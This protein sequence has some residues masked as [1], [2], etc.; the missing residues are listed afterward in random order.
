MRP[1][2]VDKQLKT[3]RT[4]AVVNDSKK[5]RQ[6][7]VLRQMKVTPTVLSGPGFSQAALTEILRDGAQQVPKAAIESEVADYIEERKLPTGR[8]SK[9]TPHTIAATSRVVTI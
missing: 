6:G 8:I 3:R 9:I 1:R 7:Q 2:V 4:L 5:P